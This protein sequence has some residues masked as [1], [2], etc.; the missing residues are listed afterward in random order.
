MEQE[1][2]LEKVYLEQKK[3]EENFEMRIMKFPIRNSINSLE[4]PKII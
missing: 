3:L 1:L 4:K 2:N